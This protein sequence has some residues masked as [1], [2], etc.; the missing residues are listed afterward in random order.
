MKA[1]STDDTVMR[2]L[3]RSSAMIS[4]SPKIALIQNA[5]SSA[6]GSEREQNGHNISYWNITVSTLGSAQWWQYWPW[7]NRQFSRRSRGS[8]GHW[9]FRICRPWGGGGQSLPKESLLRSGSA[10][11]CSRKRAER[12]R[13]LGSVRYFGAPS[14]RPAGRDLHGS[15]AVGNPRRN[16]ASGDRPMSSANRSANQHRKRFE[17][18]ENHLLERLHRD[19][20]LLV[21]GVRAPFGSELRCRL[22]TSSPSSSIPAGS[23]LTTAGVLEGGDRS[24]LKLL[25]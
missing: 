15:I 5:L 12:G 18:P 10:S 16:D 1:S 19:A 2:T 7:R 20:Q 8:C 24:L 11:L 3:T 6:F 14:A 23:A 9:D 17:L 22:E 21:L 4:R 13:C 25:V